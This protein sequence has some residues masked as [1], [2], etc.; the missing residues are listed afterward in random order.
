MPC[1]VREARLLSD[2]YKGA[3][4]GKMGS[5]HHQLLNDDYRSRL[6]SS[7]RPPRAFPE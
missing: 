3:E 7:Q 4:F 1:R 6:A 5:S 2:S